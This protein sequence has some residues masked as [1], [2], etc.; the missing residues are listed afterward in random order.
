MLMVK[1]ACDI[2]PQGGTP[3][4]PSSGIRGDPRGK[5]LF[6]S[7]TRREIMEN[8]AEAATP[9]AVTYRSHSGAP[10]VLRLENLL[11]AK[12]PSQTETRV[13]HIKTSNSFPSADLPAI[14]DNLRRVIAPYSVFGPFPTGHFDNFHPAKFCPCITRIIRNSNVKDK[15]IYLLRGIERALNF[16]SRF[17]YVSPPPPIKRY[18]MQNHELLSLGNVTSR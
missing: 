11:R 5:T 3:H 12:F 13:M 15:H 17:R 6:R 4:F 8:R 9:H 18:R 7:V 14:F 2:P 1:F 10:P 16:T